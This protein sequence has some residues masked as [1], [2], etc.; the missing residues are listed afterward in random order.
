MIKLLD[1]YI[2]KELVPPFFV[3][4]IFFSF[5]FLLSRILEITDLIVNYNIPLTSVL[6]MLLFSMPFYLQFTIPMSVMMAVLLTFM[7]F[8]GA[9]EILA[10]KSGGVSILRL[11]P[12]VCFFCIIG[13]LLTAAM[14]FYG[15]PWGKLSFKKEIYEIASKNMNISF[16]EK[17][18]LD[19][20]PGITL[21]INQINGEHMKGIF[22]EDKKTG[23]LPVTIT[24]PDGVLLRQKAG[25]LFRLEN[26]D[27]LEIDR[28]AR[29][30]NKTHFGVYSFMIDFS[31]KLA[32]EKNRKKDDEEMYY[33]ELKKFIAGRIKKDH[34]YYSA[35]IK[36]HEK[37]SL[38]AAAFFLGLIAFSLGI[39]SRAEKKSSGVVYGISIFVFYYLMLAS[40][41]SLGESDP[42]VY[43]PF[44]AMW[45]PNFVIFTI[46]IF[47]LYLS[48][49]EKDINFKFW[50]WL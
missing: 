32:K 10:L 30:I 3:S 4:I 35:V 17:T 23:K 12:S 1:R 5:V 33:T 43:P 49:K 9:N 14:T 22:I 19:S 24:A 47:L 36:V 6:K 21:Y 28:D 27:I 7:D 38:P 42:E 34:I 39:R 31:D 16:K 13:V 20:F 41:W 2:F 44:F 50:T 37:F 29:R 45:T 48:I 26:G 11:L 40:G 25:F 15:L 8:S 46:S 18:F